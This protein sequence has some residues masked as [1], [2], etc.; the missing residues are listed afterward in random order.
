MPSTDDEGCGTNYFDLIGPRRN[1]R[2]LPAD[3]GDT[4]T[5]PPRAPT[6]R[7]TPYAPDGRGSGVPLGPRDY[8]ISSDEK[9]QL[10]ALSRRHPELAPGP[11]R[12]RRVEF[13]YERHGTLCD[14]GPYDV[15]AARLFGSLAEKTGIVPFME[16]VGQV[17]TLRPTEAP[18]TSTGSSTTAPR[19]TGSTPSH[20]WPPLSPTRGSST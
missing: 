4:A 6:R 5:S 15:H 19:T 8:V 17:M 3:R 12:D 1:R 13:E 7:P 14:F 2:N 16:L 11:G 9:S 18:S 20:G 10:Q